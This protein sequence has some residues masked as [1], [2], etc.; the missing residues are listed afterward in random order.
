MN[1]PNDQNTYVPIQLDVLRR[2]MALGIWKGEDGLGGA[3]ARMCY[4][5]DALGEA[6]EGKTGLLEAAERQLKK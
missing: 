3:L 2:I 4:M 1:E 6:I 5:R